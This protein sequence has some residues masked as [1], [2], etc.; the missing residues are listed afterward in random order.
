M[1]LH[2]EDLDPETRKRLGVPEPEPEPPKQRPAPQSKAAPK[3]ATPK[4]PKAPA[5][6]KAPKAKPAPKPP[7]PASTPASPAPSGSVIDAGAGW[8]LGLIA[9]AVF[10]AYLNYGPAGARGWFAAKFLNK[11]YSPNG[12]QT[13]A[14][15]APKLGSTAPSTI[16][17]GVGGSGLTGSGGSW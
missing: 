5:T 12:A 1:P 8:V 16:A 6:P 17:P 11:P 7:T 3:A 4:P 2:A 9:Y 13:P 10:N 15:A 14:P